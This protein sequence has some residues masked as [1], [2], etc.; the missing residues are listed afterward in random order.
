M[1]K[2]KMVGIKKSFKTLIHWCTHNTNNATRQNLVKTSLSMQYDSTKR[3]WNL[4]PTHRGAVL[5]PWRCQGKRKWNGWQARKRRFYSE[6]YWTWDV[7][8]VSRQ[9]VKNKIKRWVDKQHLV[10]QCGPCIQGQDQKLILGPSPTTQA[11]L[12]SF[13]RTQSRAVICLLT[14][15]NTLRRHP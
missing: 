7:P 3:R 11:Q 15:H 5:G 4:Y 2:Q 13:N 8:G 9:N 14:R 1:A 6:V 12:L 10:M